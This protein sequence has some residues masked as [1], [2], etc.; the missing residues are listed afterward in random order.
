MDRL[1]WKVWY[2]C[3]SCVSP[4]NAEAVHHWH[5]LHRGQ[6]P[7]DRLHQRF[8]G[9]LPERLLLLGLREQ[10]C[11]LACVKYWC[12]D[13]CYHGDLHGSTIRSR[14]KTPEPHPHILPTI[15]QIWSSMVQNGLR[16]LE[17]VQKLL[18]KHCCNVSLSWDVTEITTEC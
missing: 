12:S 15:C 7:A 9:S 2:Q 14:T 3:V 8:S 16:N 5:D 13:G 4:G 11:K 18:L 10:I 6:Y 1:G 17:G